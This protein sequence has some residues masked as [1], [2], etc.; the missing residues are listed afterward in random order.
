MAQLTTATSG[1]VPAQLGFLAIYNPSLG[2]TDETM[3]DQIVYYSSVSSPSPSSS[4]S[5]TK[6]HPSSTAEEK[7]ERLRQIGLAQGMVEFGKSFSGDRPVDTI[8]TEKARVVLH[9]LEPGWWILASV[10][11]TK[12][13]KAKGKEPAA[14]EEEQPVEYSSREVKPASLLLRDLLRAHSVFLLHHDSSLSA[15]FVRTQREKFTAV[16]SRYWDL[17]LAR[18]NVM[19]HGNPLRDVFGGIK[20]AASGELGVGVGEEDRGSGERAVLEGLVPRTDGLIDLVVGK[21]GDGVEEEDAGNG[22][23]DGQQWLG[24]GQEPGPEDGAIFLGVGA[25]SRSSLRN[26]SHWMEDI[27][28]WGENAYGVKQSPTTTRSRP[29]RKRPAKSSISASAPPFNANPDASSFNL[30]LPERHASE[31]GD[32]PPG[33]LPPP[34][35]VKSGPQ[36]GTTTT[37]LE[38]TLKAPKEAGDSS[39]AS[40]LAGYLKLG[41]GTYWTLGSSDKAEETSAPSA[42]AAKEVT[43]T[44]AA[45]EVTTA[46]LPVRPTPSRTTSRDST[47]GHFLI[48]LQGNVAEATDNSGVDEI[49]EPV[50][51]NTRTLLRT[52][53]VELENNPNPLLTPSKHSHDLGSTDNEVGSSSS[54]TTSSQ[55][56]TLSNYQTHG[57]TT[58]DSQDR[59]KTTKLRVLVYAYKPFLFLLLFSPHTDSLNWET[60]YRSLHHQLAPLRKPL[61]TSTAYRPA[62]PVMPGAGGPIYDLVYDTTELTI[63]STL[64]HIPVDNSPENLTLWPGGRVEALNT[65]TQLLNIYT[66]TRPPSTELE[67][68]VKTSRGWWIVWSRILDGSPH[69]PLLAAQDSGTPTPESGPLPAATSQESDAASTGSKDGDSPTPTQDARQMFPVVSKEIFLVRKSG[70][71]TGGGGVMGSL[72][73]GGG[74]GGGWADGASRLAQGI[75]VDTRKYIEGLLSLNR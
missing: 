40:K 37:G 54:S 26:I 53:T 55:T 29:K 51:S 56:R 50:I 47:E 44:P 42:E 70:E 74:T 25:L 8:E 15:L 73:V 11:L 59:N 27:Y 30:T 71:T 68:T 57:H 9:E 64:P 24:T 61:L 4:P 45:K 21:F 35:I 41:Y 28:T 34:P 23:V 36:A 75:G 38:S 52:L 69:S 19:L 66:N 13:P 65:H 17:F 3:E 32:P 12:L 6:R 62:R 22:T 18:W 72:G 1:A 14:E 5:L 48:G 43:T 2:T 67:R 49:F 16:L 60:P 31:Q 33:L 7:N 10:D 63:H 46:A 39:S 20:I 58:F